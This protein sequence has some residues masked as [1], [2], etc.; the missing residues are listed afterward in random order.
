MVAP[1]QTSLP[2][3][4]RQLRLKQWP[5]VRLTQ[6][7]LGKALG[8]GASSV[9][10]WESAKH[11]KIPSGERLNDYAVFFSTRRSLQSKPARL[12]PLADLNQE[13]RSEYQRLTRE[14]LQLR[15]A[16]ADDWAGP[17]RGL[18][19]FPDGGRVRL[20]CG[21]PPGEGKASH[22]SAGEHNYMQ[23]AAY[24][25][26][27]SLVELFGHIRAANPTA[28]VRFELD[29]RLE[30]DDLQAHLV[31]LGSPLTNPAAR[32][33]ATLVGLP[34][35]QKADNNVDD[36]EIF[37]VDGAS[38]TK[39]A[40]VFRDGDPSSPLLED[41]G[42]FYRTRNPMNSARTLTFCSGVF[43]RGVY[44]AVRCFTDAALRAQ[45]EAYVLARFEETIEF[46]LLMRVPV[47]DHATGTPDLHVPNVVLREWPPNP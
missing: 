43:T 29:P 33:M 38:P 14:L 42:L 35:S 27:D 1:V 36:G 20:I 2:E 6:P 16:V 32:Y 4:L 45:N 19:H 31:F 10:S 30:S 24:A 26:L 5:D 39:F 40:P 34:V 15:D 3:R 12:L 8:V 28:D 11:G 13:E 41:V 7:Q 47:F 22:V 21:R 25:D 46:G 9:S 18:W 44:G 17:T 37:R 23:L